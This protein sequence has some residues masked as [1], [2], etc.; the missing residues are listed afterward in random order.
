[1]P[2]RHEAEAATADES[3]RT[4]EHIADTL[5]ETEVVPRRHV[6]IIVRLIGPQATLDLLEEATRIHESGGL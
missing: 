2:E 6:L 5:G 3:Q 4:A 1:M